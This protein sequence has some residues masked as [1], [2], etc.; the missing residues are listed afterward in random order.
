MIKKNP[1]AEFAEKI[2]LKPIEDDIFFEDDKGHKYY[3]TK[4]GFLTGI[5]YN[6]KINQGRIVDLEAKMEKKEEHIKIL[7]KQVDKLTADVMEKK[8]KISNL[9]IDHIGKKGKRAIHSICTSN[10][11]TDSE[12]IK[13]IVSI[14]I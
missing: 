10:Y 9:I 11:L 6:D 7:V 4:Y 3:P 12:K 1:L 2:G 8:E 5:Q 13:R 14:I